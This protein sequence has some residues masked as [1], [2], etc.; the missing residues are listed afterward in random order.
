VAIDGIDLL[1]DV[2]Q[3]QETDRSGGLPAALD[4]CGGVGL[5][6][7]GGDETAE[8]AADAREA[9]RLPPRAGVDRFR[10][11]GDNAS[12]AE[13]RRPD[14]VKLI[15]GMISAPAPP[16]LFAEAIEALSQ[17][18]GSAD[19]LSDVM[20]FDL[21]DYYEPE[22]GRPLSRQFVS[23]AALV[24]P[25][26]LVEAKLRTN[27]IE[28]DFA[29]RRSGKGAARRPINLDPGL[30]APSRLVLASMKDFSHRIYLGRGVYGEVTMMYR[31]GQWESLPWTFPDFASGRYDS[32][33]TRARDLLR[34][35]GEKERTP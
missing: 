23:F 7:A 17:A 13:V 14:N 32:F 24:A 19:L 22:M 28:A 16:D 27:E 1:V 3:L 2:S 4:G 26:V 8:H 6:A 9:R 34:A 15:C 31:K 10:L 5:P 35:A 11:R 33:L 12:M 30:I 29:K 18:F 20:P 21:T 25:D